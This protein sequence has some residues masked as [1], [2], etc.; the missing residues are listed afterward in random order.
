[1]LKQYMSGHGTELGVDSGPSHVADRGSRNSERS[2]SKGKYLMELLMDQRYKCS[3]YTFFWLV[4][5]SA[6]PTFLSGTSTASAA[7]PD[8]SEDTRIRPDSKDTLED[9]VVTAEKRDSTIQHTPMS[10]SAISGEELQDQGISTLEEVIHDIPGVSLRSAGPGQTELEMRGL[11]ST[12]GASPTVGFYLDDSPLTPAIFTGNGKVVVDPDLFDLNRVEVLRGP[13]GTLYGAGSMG[14]TIR[15]I[16]NQPVLDKSFGTVEADGSG[17]IG[18]GP[19]GAVNLS[20]NIPIIDDH[21]AAR[22]VLTE[23]YNSGWIDRI[24]EDPFP[25]PSNNGCLPTAFNGCARGNV[26][27]GAVKSDYKNVNW[28]HLQGARAELL[29]KPIDT[30]PILTTAF[31]QKIDQAGANTFDVPPGSGG[32]EAHYQPADV[33]E[34]F[35]DRF[36]LFSNTITYDLGFSQATAATSYWNRVEQLTQDL[37]ETYQNLFYLPAYIT[38]SDQG[39]TETDTSHQVSE[40]IRLT[41]MDTGPLSWIGGLFYSE[42]GSEYNSYAADPDLCALSSGGCAANPGGLAYAAH[43]PYQIRQYAEFSEVSLKFT[44]GIIAT[45]GL[46]HFDFD[47]HETYYQAGLFSASGNTGVTSGVVDSKNSGWTPKFNLAYEPND[48]LTIYSTIAKGFRPGGVNLPLPSSGPDNC[49]PSLIPLGYANGMAPLSYKPDSIWSYEVGE[50]AKLIGDSLSINSDFYY[51]KWN[52]VQ[53]P[54]VPACGFLFTD[55]AG[56]AASYGPELEVSYVLTHEL[57]A[58]FS[59]TYTHATITSVPAGLPFSVGEKILNIPSYTANTS[60]LYRIPLLGE[61]ALVA[62]LS[63][64]IVGPTK[65]VSYFYVTLPAYDIV[66]MRVELEHGPIAYAVYV[67]NATNEHAQL[68]ANNTTMSVNSPSFYRVATNQPATIGLS[69][70]YNFGS[71]K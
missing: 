17:T 24:V 50:K 32:N 5:F 57:S 12:A 66:N 29:A 30:L 45:V 55:N 19:N 61:S 23:K 40:E 22:V 64:S 20:A 60:L 47:N 48:N 13:Q 69:V 25:F 15:L 51:I 59:G 8:A 54:I 10:I 41:S 42:L 27:A 62:R 18:G 11:A 52:D 3:L 56:N 44:P 36:Y 34:P 16:T 4:G 53:Q 1:M 39:I 63:N 58:N 37:S 9:I 33:K 31:Y 49:S 71:S 6:M 2:R 21:V 26:L 38:S 65:D 28:E 35:V 14:G 43:N 67:N 68:T 7:T 46:R 70:R